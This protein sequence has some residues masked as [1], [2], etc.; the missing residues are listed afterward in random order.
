MP[1]Q[2]EEGKTPKGQR[3]MR[4]MVSGHVSLADAEAMKAQMKPGMPYHKALVISIVDKSADYSPES[5]KHFSTF[6]PLYGRMATVV[7][8][9]VLRALINFMHRVFGQPGHFRLFNTEAEAL[10]WLDQT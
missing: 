3:C 7:N 1:I 8:S 4:A 10:A 2:I 9:A 6:Q 5:R